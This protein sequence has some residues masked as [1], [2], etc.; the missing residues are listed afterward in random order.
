MRTHKSYIV[1]MREAVNLHVHGG[2]KYDL[3]LRDGRRM[4]VSR[5]RYREVLDRLGA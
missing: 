1:D 5:T 3:E 4:P 2:G